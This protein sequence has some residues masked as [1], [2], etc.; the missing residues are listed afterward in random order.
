MKKSKIVA[1]VPAGGAGTRMGDSLPK[2]YLDING[3]PMI[4]HTLTALASVERI[5]RI[6]VV[7]APNDVY[8]SRLIQAHDEAYAG[9]IVSRNVGGQTRAQ[10][11]LNGMLSVGD[12]FADEDWCLVHD[13]AR[14]CISPR[15][16]EQFLDELEHESIGGLLALPVADTLKRGNSDQRVEGT[17]DRSTLWRAQTPQMFRLGL[18][19]R[20]LAESLDATDEAQAVERLGH[21]P[22]LVVGD[23]ANLKVTYATDLKLAS[24][25]LLERTT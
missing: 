5:S 3:K 7:N 19:R 10:S 12:D 22:R 1:I 21:Q 9:K 15:L 2:Q 14:P 4:S 23:S 25:L 24:L 16:I 18:L 6:V 20:A 8:F 17:V 11:V 13:A